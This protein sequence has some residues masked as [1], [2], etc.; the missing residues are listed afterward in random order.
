MLVITSLRPSS[1]CSIVTTP[2]RSASRARH[3]RLARFEELFD[4]RETGG[5]VGAGHTA[6]VEGAH[7]EL[8]A[9]LADRLRGNDA[10]CLAKIDELAA[11]QITTVARRANTMDCFA[12]HDRADIELSRRSR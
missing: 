8:G 5:D 2:S 9:R 6:G 10:D 7:R 1:V 12:G 3:L 11:G 4:A